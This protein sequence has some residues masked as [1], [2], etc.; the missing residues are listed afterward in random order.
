[1]N[2]SNAFLSITVIGRFKDNIHQAVS[3][4]I[5]IGLGTKLSYFSGYLCEL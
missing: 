3:A 1:M 2:K 5:K 4:R